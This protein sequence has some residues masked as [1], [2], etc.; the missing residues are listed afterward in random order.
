MK[1][2]AFLFLLNFGLVDQAISQSNVYLRNSTWQDFD[3]E[4]TQTGSAVDPD[5]WSSAEALVKGWFETTGHDVL[6]VNRGSS[7]VALDDTAYFNVN[8]NG[9]TDSI[10]IKLRVIGISD[11]SELDFSIEGEGFSEPWYDDAEFHEINT[12]LNG[13]PVVIKFKPDN[14][15][16]NMDR[17]VRFAIHDLPVYEIDAVDFDD[18][19]VLN[20]MFYNIQMITLGISGMPQAS[21]RGA[22]FPAQ[23]SPYQ[24]VVA[25]MEAFDDGPRENDLAP[26]M[27][28]ADFPYRTT[29][30]NAPGLIP[31]PTNGGVVIFSKWPIETESEIDF[32]L[33]G[34]ASQDCFANKG[35]KYARINKLGK[36]YHVFATHMDAGG[37]ADD[38]EARRSQ[39]AEIRD[40]IANLNIPQGE[41]VVFGGDF[42]TRPSEGDLD[43]IAFLDTMSPV[44]PEHIG[45]YE[46]NF[47]DNFGNIIDHAWIDRHHLIPTVATNEIMTFRSLDPVLWDISEFSDHRC[48]LGRF[49]YPDITKI[50]GDT[51][52]CPDENLSIFIDTDFPVTYKWSKDGTELSG[53]DGSELTFT[54]AQESESGLYTCQVSY[55]VIYG[56]WG[57]SLNNLF[58]PNGIDTVH[59]NLAF[60]YDI[61]IDEILCNVAVN[62]LVGNDINFY[63]NPSS[64]TVR[65]SGLTNYSDYR[66]EIINLLGQP[67]GEF[68]VKNGS[69]DVSGLNTG[70]YLLVAMD[71]NG[72]SKIK[73]MM[74]D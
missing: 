20:A 6:S 48:A 70:V 24:D 1:K 44:I 69:I 10:T 13:K 43:F 19:N 66:F 40:M 42:N 27:E 36:K 7:V 31:I 4:I 32:E 53:E 35:V 73:R 8:L 41:P 56:A 51:L 3:I 37:G 23:I 68:Q 61:I 50:G 57:D 39:M 59:A 34:D 33:C 45:F 60:N 46:S 29:I 15:D 55:D 63:P 30:L 72:N 49:E 2:L 64:E 62:E 38:I 18:P 26:A 12:M 58:Y 67:F 17:N 71:K 65:V 54:S 21:E 16:S 5:E 47:G 9:A 11:G 28:A 52:I 74:I 25:F 14:D 22:L